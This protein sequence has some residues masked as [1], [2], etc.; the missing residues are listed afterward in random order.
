[1]AVRLRTIINANADARVPDNSVEAVSAEDVRL[2]AK[3]IADSAVFPE[4]DAGIDFF[5]KAGITGNMLASLNM[6]SVTDDGVGLL[7]GTIATDFADAN[8]TAQVAVLATTAQWNTTNT[9]GVGFTAQ[10]A[11]TFSCA[12]SRMIEGNTAVAD[13]ID[14]TAWFV[15]GVGTLV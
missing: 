9:S 6:T 5:V 15:S 1:M 14:P 12:F 7:S 2:M 3:D 8:W 10:A 4:D 11:G 13:L